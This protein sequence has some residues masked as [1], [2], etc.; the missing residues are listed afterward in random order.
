MEKDIEDRGQRLVDEYTAAVQKH[1]WN[2][3]EELEEGL[4]KLGFLSS[5]K[6]GAETTATL[7]ESCLDYVEQRVRIGSKQQNL[8]L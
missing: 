2:L 7:L 6:E 4:K 1:V 5:H 8:L 3:K